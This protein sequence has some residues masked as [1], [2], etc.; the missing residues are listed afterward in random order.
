MPSARELDAV[1]VD[2]MGTLVELDEPVERLQEAL[3]G[4]N[5]ERP[6]DQVAA[7]FKRE[8]AYYLEHKLETRDRNSLAELR[9]RCAAVFLEGAEA[10]ID[11]AE[12]SPAFVDSM[13]FKPPDG[14]VPALERLRAGG[15]A[16]ACV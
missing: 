16:L 12:F 3:R 2:A 9:R 1:T 8:I 15:L 7:A 6:R 11:P 5:A 14:A 4:W 13:V 10:E